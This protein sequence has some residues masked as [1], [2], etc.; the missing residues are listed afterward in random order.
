MNDTY[1]GSFFVCPDAPD[2]MDGM[3][4]DVWQDGYRDAMH[5][6]ARNLGQV[7]L[8]FDQDDFNYAY[9]YRQAVRDIMDYQES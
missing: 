4:A 8:G 1:D 6:Y 9:G 5:H 2:G 3:Y 7:F